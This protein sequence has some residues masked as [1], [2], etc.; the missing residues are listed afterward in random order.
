MSKRYTVDKLQSAVSSIKQ[1]SYAIDKTQLVN[2]HLKTVICQPLP[3]C[4][5]SISSVSPTCGIY[6]GV[7][8][9]VA[10][11]LIPQCL[12]NIFPAVY[13]KPYVR[14]PKL[15]LHSRMRTCDDFYRKLPENA[16]KDNKMQELKEGCM[17]ERL[18][19][20]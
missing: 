3:S 10:E 15:V 14:R 4:E 5:P 11:D 13:V 16:T 9:L 7:N 8:S 1:K 19:K 6:I 12:S 20:K 18:E 17:K 2:N